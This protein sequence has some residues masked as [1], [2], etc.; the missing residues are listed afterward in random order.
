MAGRLDEITVVTFPSGSVCEKGRIVHAEIRKVAADEDDRLL[1]VSDIT[2]FHPTD[3]IWS[4]QPGDIGTAAILGTTI[5]IIGSLTG[6]YH[7]SID[8]LL[9]DREISAPRSDTEWR[10]H[11]VH[12][13]P[14]HPDIDPAELAGEIIT[15]S[16]NGSFR[17]SLNR[18]HTACHLMA[19]AL[20]KATKGLWTKEARQD[21]LGNPNLDQTAIQQSYLVSTSSTDKYRF[22]KSLRKAG[23]EAELFFSQL[24]VIEKQISEQVGQWID[25]GFTVQMVA[26]SP[27]LNARRY[28][29]ASLA[30][31]NVRIPCGGTHVKSSNE[32]GTVAITFDRDQIEPELT[33]RTSVS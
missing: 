13:L 10:F 16:V 31:G 20:N 4:D 30:D 21:A 3:H 12:V 1:V 27:S 24:N 8:H 29:E 32:I 2:P 9:I 11:V 33:I 14:L 25:G 7:P 6:A 5:P 23:F 22:G 19:L 18:A 26:E 17:S 28:W 15:L